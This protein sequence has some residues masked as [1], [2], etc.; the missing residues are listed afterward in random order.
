MEFR[1]TIL[2][3]ILEDQ[4]LTSM[5]VEDYLNSL[6][7]KELDTWVKTFIQEGVITKPN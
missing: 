1:K 7:E 2:N 3:N 4:Y 5:C 6:T